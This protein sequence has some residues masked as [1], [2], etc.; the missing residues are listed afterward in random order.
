MRIEEDLRKRRERI[1]AWQEAKR[2]KELE[3]QQKAVEEAKQEEENGAEVR[4]MNH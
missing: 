2:K 3:D 4:M 1:K